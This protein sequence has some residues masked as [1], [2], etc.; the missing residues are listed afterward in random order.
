M[1]PSG[2]SSTL[3]HPTRPAP[4]ARTGR[5]PRPGRPAGPATGRPA[6]R[7]QFARPSRLSRALSSAVREPDR[8]APRRP[9]RRAVAMDPRMQERRA[10]VL[11]Q[12]A[13]RRLRL[14][15]A[16]LAVCLLL[17][18]GWAVVHSRLFGARVVTVVGVPPAERAA[19]VRA[20]GLAGAPPL[21][22]VG[23][24][25]AAAVERLPWV[26]TAAVAREWPDGVRIAVTARAPVAVVDDGTASGGVAEVDRDGRVQ[27]IVAAAPTG[28]VSL[29]G[30][31]APGAPGTM[32]GDARAALAVAAS[33][34][35]AF[36]AQVTQVQED[37]GGD[38]TLHLTSPVTVYLGSTA[39]LP[40]KYEDAAALLAGAT[41]APGDVIDVSVPATP[42]VRT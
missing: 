31:A 16:A 15:L 24:G 1:S 35:K 14:S 21:I 26:A 20:A 8:A 22:D 27:G 40:A 33:L 5:P 29:T 18:G 2:R 42:V 34:P 4:A 13:R 23:A 36:A 28:L 38:V 41:L 12:Q 32:L 37:P 9:A 3:R 25:T 7:G 11:R 10:D 6:A 30:T 17:A 19:V 39:D